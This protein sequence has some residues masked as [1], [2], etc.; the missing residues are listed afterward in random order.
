MTNIEIAVMGADARRVRQHGL[1]TSGMVGATVCFTFDELWDN[2][3]RV[4]VFRC[5]SEIRDVIG[6]QEAVKI[7]P[8]VLLPDG[9]LF[10]GIEGRDK[11]GSMVIPTVWVRAAYVYP[12]ANVSGDTS[13]NPELPVWAQIMDMLGNLPELHTLDKSSLVAAVNEVLR[14]GGGNVD[15][16]IIAQAVE[17][18]LDENPPA[19]GEPGKDG[20]YYSPTVNQQETG[21][22]TFSFT[23]SK[24]GMSEVPSVTVELPQ[25]PQGVTPKFKV[26]NVETLEPGMDAQ[27]S[28]TGSDVE[29]VLRFAIPRGK[30]GDSGKSAYEYARDSGYTGTEEEFAKNLAE[31]YSKAKIDAA[32]GAYITDVDAL[33]GGDS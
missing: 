32:L 29:P 31:V 25:G 9:E 10:I 11:D 19:P 23:P 14:S 27:V 12:G 22:A 5:G 20:G 21:K 8:E 7:P 33:I 28:I 16:D 1:L 24:E 15:P 18:Y 26:G 4:A 6:A 30:D 3:S 2:L 13:T 17:T